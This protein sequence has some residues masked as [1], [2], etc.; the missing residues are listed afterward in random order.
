MFRCFY[1][2]FACS[3]FFTA[4]SFANL[5]D[6]CL[7]VFTKDRSVFSQAQRK[8][9]MSIQ[10]AQALVQSKNIKTQQE[11]YKW[12]K[13][14]DRPSNFPYN[15]QIVYR[16]NWTNWGSFL[17]TGNSRKQDWM[18]YPEAQ[19]LVQSENIKTQKELYDWIKSNK[20]PKNFPS[21]PH[22]VYTEWEG[23]RPFL[24]TGNSRKHR[25]D[26]MSYPEAQALMEKLGIK[27][28]KEFYEW[29]RSGNRPFNF[30]SDPRTTYNEEWKGWGSFLGTGNSYKK[31]WMSYPEAQALMEKLGI[32][33]Q[34]EFREW[35]KSGNRPFNFPS[36]PRTI[37][38]EEWKGW[39]SFLRNGNSR[40][41][42]WM[43]Y[44]EAQALM[45]KLGIKTQTE[46]REWSKLGNRPS[47][48]PSDP[49][50]IYKERWT[51]W[52]SFL[53]NGNSYK[54]RR[55]NHTEAKSRD[56]KIK[57]RRR[58]LKRNFENIPIDLEK[59]NVVERGKGDIF[60]EQKNFD[61]LMGY[62]ELKSLVQSK[63]I[64]TRQEFYGWVLFEENSKNIPVD[65][66]KI[67]KEQWKGWDIFFGI[68][69]S[70][71]LMDYEEAKYYAR[72]AGLKNSF[73]FYSVVEI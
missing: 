23:L 73:R 20:R 63:N 44:P 26:W 36:D 38:N 52:G 67:Y 28:R 11:F 43:S 54:R 25:K 22:T 27:T 35:S 60:P 17:G 66:D 40:K 48:F 2:F 55:I 70:Q 64:K 34:T 62:E 9:W 53:R 56:I 10:E 3:L 50:T 30:P 24:G 69:P 21:S 29:S 46:F 31:D 51:S 72:D 42:D 57:E 6:G 71:T 41:Q 59:A 32:K 39:G 19:A 7:E 1:L 5:K 37:Y 4:Y 18:S 45:E 8:D 13:S 68:E 14:G 61:Q 49:S 16:K 12:A 58:R 33:T 47:N 65:P 15:P